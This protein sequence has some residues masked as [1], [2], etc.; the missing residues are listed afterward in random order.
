MLFHFALIFDEQSKAFQKV[1]L[2][3]WKNARKDGPERGW[4]KDGTVFAKDLGSKAQ[5]FK[6]AFSER[7]KK[8]L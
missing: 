4:G 5:L 2:N 6:Y 8:K 7:R 3:D 1:R